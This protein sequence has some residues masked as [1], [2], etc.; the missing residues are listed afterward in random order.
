M[1]STVSKFIIYVKSVA[2]CRFWVSFEIYY[3]SSL[4]LKL[5]SHGP[6]RSLEAFLKINLCLCRTFYW[7]MHIF[8][9]NIKIIAFYEIFAWFQFSW[10]KAG[11]ISTGLCTSWPFRFKFKFV[12]YYFFFCMIPYSILFG[13]FNTFK[14]LCM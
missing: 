4:I 14:I 13:N 9:W 8:L 12:N 7:N 5:H 11:K 6:V 3:E 1:D 10:E 2:L